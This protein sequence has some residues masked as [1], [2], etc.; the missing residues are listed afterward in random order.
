MTHKSKI[1]ILGG[2]EKKLRVT[3]DWTLDLVFQRSRP[4]M[5]LRSRVQRQKKIPS[6][7]I[8]QAAR[9]VHRYAAH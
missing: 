2:L 3:L 6:C 9:S 4:F 8:S 5:P 1:R 7:I